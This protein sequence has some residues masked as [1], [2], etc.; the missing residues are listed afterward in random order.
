MKK[1]ITT[2]ALLG[3]SSFA[4]A[5]I[6]SNTNNAGGPRPQ[7]PDAAHNLN[8]V[9]NDKSLENKP[10]QQGAKTGQ[11]AQ[12][13]APA[14]TGKRQPQAKTPEEFKAFNEAMAKPDPASAETAADDFAKAYPE[15]ELRSVLYQRV[16]SLYQG[17]NNA[18]KTVEIGKKTLELDPDN[19]PAM[20]TVA[21]VIAN[22]TRETDLDKDERQAEAKKYANQAIEMINSGQG[23]PAGTPP[24]KVSMYKDLILSMAYAALGTIE[25][26]NKNYPQAEQN[27]RKSVESPQV[28]PDPVSWLQL[29][30][31]L[32]R[33]AKYADA[34][35]AASKCVEVSQGHPANAYCTS[36]RDRLQKL[37]NNPPAAKPATPAPAT[38]P[39][40][41]SPTTTPSTPK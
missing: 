7:E 36:E 15:S 22:R 40:A 24:D 13:Q 29:A 16:M 31:T 28:Q 12:A 35:A 32:D 6:P 33:E 30:L 21:S 34:L 5:Q 41:A 9:S 4:L 10:E 38:A 37:A 1:F 18:D 17:A 11:Q 2:L 8:H 19:A 3:A 27:L 25:F 14:A 23:I 26:N 20:V 39:A